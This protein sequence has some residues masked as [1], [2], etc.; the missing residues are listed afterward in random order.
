VSDDQRGYPGAPPGWYP[1]PAGG[2]GQRWWDGYAW[3]E[4]VVTPVA[5]PPPPAWTVASARFA[6][7][8]TS[9]LVQSEL[10][11]VTLARVAVVVFAIHYLIDFI[12]VQANAT[13]F[14]VIGDHIRT[15]WNDIQ[16]HVTAPSFSETTSLSWISGLGTAAALMAVI[17][18]CVWQHRSARAARALGLPATHS[19]AWGV[20]SWFVPIVNLFMPYQAIRDCLP[21]GHPGRALVLRWWLI[22]M[23]AW[24]TALAAEIAACFSRPAG[25]VLGIMSVLFAVGLL[26]TAPRVVTT[27][28]GTHQALVDHASVP[29]AA[30]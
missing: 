21:A 12:V 8:A 30:S 5:P 11:M 17:L 13:Q 27:I 22:L 6:S 2:P 15:T 1:D 25:L 23:G 4:S 18:A 19:P 14:L 16:N 10:G 26:A 9:N 24:S 28:S 20:G 3:N 29:V 7:A